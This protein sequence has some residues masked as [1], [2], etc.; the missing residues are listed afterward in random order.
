MLPLGTFQGGAPFTT[1]RMQ[2]TSLGTNS[3]DIHVTF[4]IAESY[5]CYR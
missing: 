2:H 3:M 4:Y 5:A 1:R